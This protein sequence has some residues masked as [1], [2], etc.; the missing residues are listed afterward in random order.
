MSKGGGSQPPLSGPALEG[1]V[2]AVTPLYPWEEGQP[3]E[4][5]ALSSLLQLQ[6]QGTG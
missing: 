2:A 1:T 6:V 5:E 4:T 3:K